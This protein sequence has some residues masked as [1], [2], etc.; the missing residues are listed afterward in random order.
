M[1][2]A[3]GIGDGS[4]ATSALLNYPSGVALDGAGNLFVAD[5]DG[6]R[7]RRVDVNTGVI[8]T[9]AGTGEFGFDGDGDLATKARLSSPSGV[10]VD[11]AGNLFIAERDGHRIRGHR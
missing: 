11:G 5:S 6:E 1:T 9:V 3:G 4:P 7:I 10:A 8:T 2:V